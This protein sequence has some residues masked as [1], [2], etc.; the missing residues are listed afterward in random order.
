MR[1]GMSG[2]APDFP[3]LLTGRAVAGEAPRAA[4]IRAAQE[5]ADPGLVLYDPLSED[6]HVAMVFAPDRPRAE[7]AVVLPL[8]G[9]A[10]QNA[11]GSVA[12]PEVALHLGWEGAVHING[13][14]AGRIAMIAPPCA[15]DD[16]PDWMVVTIDL[17]FVPRSADGGETPG[18]TSLYAEGCG[19]LTPMP[20]LESYARHLLHWLH[21]WE[22]DGLSALHRDYSG[23]VWQLGEDVTLAGRSG[24]FLG[25]DETLGA[26]VK[27]D[28]TTH[29][30]PLSLM[31]EQP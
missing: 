11:L 27:Q 6:L 18:E 3:P 2:G 5:G 23:L 26:L 25:L 4:A 10:L 9:V 14:Q 30:L 24:H 15:E 28:G 8:C 21:D 7:A 20:L 16:V 12:P 1:D 13:G 31:M 29:L 17:H 19:D 22:T